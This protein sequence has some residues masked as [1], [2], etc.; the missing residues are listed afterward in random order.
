[1]AIYLDADIVWGWKDFA[2]LDRVALTIAAQQLGQRVV[3]VGLTADEAEATLRRDL[4]ESWSAY[5]DAR[6]KINKL[7]DRDALDQVP[8]S[9]HDV[10]AD[11]RTSLERHIDLI[12]VAE[13]AAEAALQREIARKPPAKALLDGK[14]K[15][16]GGAG[17]R[18][19]AMWLTIVEDHKSRDEPGY[20]I[21]KNASDF[22]KGN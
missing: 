7:F 15:D 17:A 12:P 14:G 5:E 6:K 18:D 21:T 1:M 3:M 4:S 10:V 2:H 8:S 20:F 19:A 9:L 11:W 22:G 13:R 16:Q